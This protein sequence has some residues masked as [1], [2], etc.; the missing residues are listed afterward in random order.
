MVAHRRH[1][2]VVKATDFGGIKPGG[3]AEGLKQGLAL[4]FRSVM[5]G[6]AVEHLDQSGGEQR[7]AL[8]TTLMAE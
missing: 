2:L 4:V 8:E 7:I 3:G 1:G 5:A 6:E